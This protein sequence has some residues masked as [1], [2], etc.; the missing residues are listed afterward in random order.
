MLF[1]C[2]FVPFLH[3]E[4]P[5]TINVA[6]IESTRDEENGLLAKIQSVIDHRERIYEHQ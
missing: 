4:T 1:A 3:T 6:K 5:K 2:I